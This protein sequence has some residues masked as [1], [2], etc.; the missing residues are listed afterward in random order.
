MD[1]IHRHEVARQAHDVE[2]YYVGEKAVRPDLQGDPPDC[3]DCPEIM[4]AG[5]RWLPLHHP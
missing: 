4:A 2:M 1:T 5:G 3:P